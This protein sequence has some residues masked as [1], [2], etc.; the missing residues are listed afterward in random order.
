MEDHAYSVDRFAF[1]DSTHP[2]SSSNAVHDNNEKDGL[3]SLF[4]SVADFELHIENV[5]D[6]AVKSLNG[7][8]ISIDHEG[9]CII[10]DSTTSDGRHHGGDDII[11]NTHRTS[12]CSTIH[13]THTNESYR[14]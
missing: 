11:S 12:K 4:G 2:T 6:K 1:L 3:T 8:I 10:D 5:R 13:R 9:S 7:L 14:K